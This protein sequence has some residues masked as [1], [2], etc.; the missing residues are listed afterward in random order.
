MRVAIDGSKLRD[1]YAARVFGELIQKINPK[2]YGKINASTLKIM[3][4]NYDMAR[5]SLSLIPH[6]PTSIALESLLDG[7]DAAVDDFTLRKGYITTT[8]ERYANKQAAYE[9]ASEVVF[10]EEDGDYM[11]D[12]ISEMIKDLSDKHHE[13][14]KSLAKYIL[15]IEKEKQSEDKAAA[16]EDNDDYVEDDEFANLGEKEGESGADEKSGEGDTGSDASNPFGSDADNGEGSEGAGQDGGSDSGNT[17]DGGD[18][19]TT[20]TDSSEGSSSGDDNPFG[21]D[22]SAEGDTEKDKSSGDSEGGN[23]FG[24]DSSDGNGDSGNSDGGNTFDNSSSSDDDNVESSS[25]SGGNPFESATGFKLSDINN[26]NLFAVLGIESGDIRSYVGSY[27]GN[28]MKDE[29]EDA[30]KSYGIESAEFAKKKSEYKAISQLAIE[31][32]CATIATM[33]SFG[34]KVDTSLIKYNI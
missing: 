7:I 26:D 30:Y 4:F 22:S 15:K 3:G 29:L 5:E 33:Y 28:F 11:S 34:I 23:P 1:A 10:E 6:Y 13:E 9:D 32:V 14:I 8:E 19:S 27:V 31:S 12:I 18:D 21:G 20:D 24:G 17:F 2:T 16:E 25:S